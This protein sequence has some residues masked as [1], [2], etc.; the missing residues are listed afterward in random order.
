MFVLHGGFYLEWY[1]TTGTASIYIIFS[2]EAPNPYNGIGL[3]D[4]PPRFLAFQNS[5]SLFYRSRMQLPV[6][7]ALV[8]LT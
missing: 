5:S 8:V 6:Y 2:P 1:S 4:F 7:F 3:P